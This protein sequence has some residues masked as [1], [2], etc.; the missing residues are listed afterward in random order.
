MWIRAVYNSNISVSGFCTDR[1]KRSDKIQ[2]FC[3]EY[4]LNPDEFTKLLDLELEKKPAQREIAALLKIAAVNL[5]DLMY[6]YYSGSDASKAEINIYPE[7][8]TYIMLNYTNKISVKKI[9][10]YCHCSESHINHIFKRNNGLSI[11]Q[12]V[13]LLRIKKAKR[14]LIN[15]NLSISEIAYM[16]GFS[17]ANYFTNIFKKFF[18]GMSPKEYRKINGSF[19]QK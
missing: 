8:L 16:T 17:E 15:T 12:Y 19:K 18:E 14:L 1:P 3:D 2:K 11:S 4:D 5:A 7:I 6:D 10:E 9:S 13:N